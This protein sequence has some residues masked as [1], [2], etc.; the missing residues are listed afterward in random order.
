MVNEKELLE[1]YR[2][3]TPENKAHLLS[4]AHA[5]RAT[6]KNGKKRSLKSPAKKPRRKTTA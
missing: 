2:K 4:M 5:I 3:M 6:Q 1:T